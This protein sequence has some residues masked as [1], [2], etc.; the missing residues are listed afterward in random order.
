MG[1]IF[2]LTMRNFVKVMSKF[3]IQYMMYLNFWGMFV[4]ASYLHCPW[5]TRNQSLVENEKRYFSKHSLKIQVGGVL[6][7]TNSSYHFEE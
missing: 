7:Y 4:K 5:L 2:K 3:I 1:I 6:N